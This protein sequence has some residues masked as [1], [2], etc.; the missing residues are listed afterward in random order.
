MTGDPAMTGNQ[1]AAVAGRHIVVM[2]V[3]GCGKT[4]I[5][6]AIAARLGA[7]FVDGDSLHPQA[8]I[9]KMAAGAPLNDGDRAPW[10]TEIGRHFAASDAGLVIACSA[11]KRSYRD[12]IRSGD[13]S[14]AFLH[15]HGTR[16]LLAARM[17]ARPGHFMP[18]SLLDSQL[19]TLEPLDVDEAGLV[20]DIANTVGEI[21]SE[22]TRWIPS[23]VAAV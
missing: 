1:N 3:S 21:A 4:T 17:A 20:V 13:S 11:L 19:A 23:R 16:D 2:G 15:L 12:I 22:T 18:L 14:V 9:D 6:A 7:E 10:L 8:N 5:G